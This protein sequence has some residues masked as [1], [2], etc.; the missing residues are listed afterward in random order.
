MCQCAVCASGVPS[1]AADAPCR[2]D[3]QARGDEAASVPT[4]IVSNSLRATRCAMV[5][6]LRELTSVGHR[7]S[8]RR[9][10]RTPLSRCLATRPQAPDP[11]DGSPVGVGSSR[12]APCRPEPRQAALRLPHRLGL[13]LRLGAGLIQPIQASPPWSHWPRASLA[14]GRCYSVSPASIGEFPD[15]VRLNH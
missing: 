5:R 1:V 4:M 7:T 3:V 11:A 2:G 13:L 10:S 9:A 14:L 6:N 15:L 8:R 12:P